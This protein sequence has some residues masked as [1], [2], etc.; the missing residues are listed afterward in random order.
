MTLLLFTLAGL[1]SS[2]VQSTSDGNQDK[3]MMDELLTR[4]TTYIS[5]HHPD[6][7]A[8][9]P[10]D[11][12]W[13]QVSKTKKVGYT[14][15]VYQGNG[16]EVS[17]GLAATAEP[18]YEITAENEAAGIIWKGTVKDSTVTEITYMAK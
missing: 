6:A 16:W 13:T 9:L 11:I 3:A 4:V 5:E 12:S 18:L 1:A 8:S 15:Y 14:R 2:L 10:D 17:I 7:A